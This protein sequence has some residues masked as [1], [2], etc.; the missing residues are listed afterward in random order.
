MPIAAAVMKNFRMP[1]PPGVKAMMPAIAAAGAITR[2]N[3]SDSSTP[4]SAKASWK[5]HAV[6]TYFTASINV[7]VIEVLGLLRMSFQPRAKLE[8]A[9]RN[10]LDGSSVV[11]SGIVKKTPHITPM[12]M[13]TASMIHAKSPPESA[14]ATTPTTPTTADEPRLIMRFAPYVL[15]FRAYE[16]SWTDFM[17]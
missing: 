17:Y 16:R 4:S 6:I 14:Y 13:K 1:I 9:R 10:R 11:G 15:P 8:T 2:K 7:T 12:Q 3:H 5:R